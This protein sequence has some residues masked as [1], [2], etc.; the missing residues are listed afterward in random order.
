[1]FYF[2]FYTD[3]EINSETIITAKIIQCGEESLGIAGGVSI[4]NLNSGGFGT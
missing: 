2:K 4:I 1:L 3:G